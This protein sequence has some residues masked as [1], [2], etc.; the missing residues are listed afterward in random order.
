MGASRFALNRKAMVWPVLSTALKRQHYP[1]DVMLL[2][3]RWYLAYSLSLRNLEEMIAERAIGVDHSTVHRWVIKFGAVV[4]K[5]VSEPWQCP[6]QGPFVVSRS[7]SSW[8]EAKFWQPELYRDIVNA[9]KPREVRL[10]QIK[11]RGM[12][13]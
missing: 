5:D 1:L 10:I 11:A 7:S 8:A 3:V 9:T 13:R 12:C 4:R 2:C 6:Q